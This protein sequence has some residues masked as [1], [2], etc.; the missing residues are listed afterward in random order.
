MSTTLNIS[1]VNVERTLPLISPRELKKELPLTD[2]I[3]GHVYDAREVIKKILSGENPRFLLIAGPCS[4]H[5]EK[6]AMEYAEKLAL[7]RDKVK[8]SIYVVMRVY[9]EKPRT[10]TGWKGLI[11]DPY[12]DGSYN[13]PEG[14]KRARRIL[15]KINEMGLPAAS[16]FL[17]P[18]IPQYISNLVSWAAIGARTTESQT[19]REMASGL[20]MPVGY[21]NGTDG[22]IEV[23]LNAMKSSRSQHSF[24]GIDQD[25][26]TSVVRTRGNPWG[27]LILRGGKNVPNYDVVSIETAV[28]ELQKEKLNPLVIVDCSHDN[29]RKQYDKQTKVLKEIL[30]QKAN[31][32]RYIVGAMLESFLFDG[33]QKIVPTQELKYGVSV[34][35]ACI[36]WDKTE[37]AVMEAQEA[38]SRIQISG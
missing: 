30:I 17:D 7:L 31:G 14:L 1:D 15:L 32:N 2:S 36:G 35:D 18:I 33:N 25:G 22:S 6:A 28:E 20:S 12:M 11:N 21:K 29:S 10:T 27:N 5:D 19:H 24:I 34:T 37:E 3:K 16:E 38:L 23:A 13:M 26:Y 9:F 8:D 4:I